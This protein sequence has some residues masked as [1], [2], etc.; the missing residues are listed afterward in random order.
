MDGIRSLGYVAGSDG[1]VRPGTLHD[2]LVMEGFDP[3]ELVDVTTGGSEIQNGFLDRGEKK[4]RRF[5]ATVRPP[6]TENPGKE[7]LWAAAHHNYAKVWMGRG[8][9]LE[10][11]NEY[12]RALVMDPDYD[13]AAW[14]RVYA[15]N[16]ARNSEAA[17]RSARDFLE[18]H[19]EAWKV[20]L[21]LAFAL[22]LQNK[23]PDAHAELQ[24]IVEGAPASH[25]A[26]QAAT[27][28]LR[29]LGT[30]RETRALDSYLA[31]A[32]AGAAEASGKPRAVD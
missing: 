15:L 22:A 13:D 5:F 23:T 25:E 19:P 18:N 28:F 2:E 9:Y 21:H 3:K 20:R 31:S 12:W 32:T 1:S 7:R 16:L 8:Q 17:E 26:R 14:S 24:S 29:S 11:A 6:S 27:V 4:L 30:P 10:A